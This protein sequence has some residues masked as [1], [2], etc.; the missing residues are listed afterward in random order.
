MLDPVVHAAL[1]VIFAA[2]VKA[3]WLYVFHTDLPAD[4]YTQIAAIIVA[5][6]LSLFGWTLYVRLKIKAFKSTPSY[7]PPFS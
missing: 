6:I 1:V 3:V 4:T 5:Y 7:H 2:L